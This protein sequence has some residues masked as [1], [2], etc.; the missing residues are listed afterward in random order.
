MICTFISNIIT[1]YTVVY[2][3]MHYY[4]KHIDPIMVHDRTHHR[5]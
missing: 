3:V 2:I 5:R 4:I 1:V